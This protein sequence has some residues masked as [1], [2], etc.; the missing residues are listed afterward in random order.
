MPSEPRHLSEQE[1]SI[2]QRAGELFVEP[3]PPAP[4]KA[5]K[6][7]PVYLRE[8]PAVP[9]STFTQV[10]LW[11]VGVIV[12]LLFAAALW[13]ATHLR[14]PPPPRPAPPP[15]E[16]AAEGAPEG[17]ATLQPPAAARARVSAA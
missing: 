10:V 6:P 17:T 3:P 4:S 12:V 15:A 8:T 7:F 9:L 2:K 1:Y 16:G 14:H 13:R 5:A 11:I